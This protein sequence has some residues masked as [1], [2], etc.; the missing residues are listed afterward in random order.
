MTLIGLYSKKNDLN[1]RWNTCQYRSLA[2]SARTRDRGPGTIYLRD[3]G[4]DELYGFKWGNFWE[5]LY[6]LNGL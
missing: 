4:I 5:K 2:G 3:Y 6:F 1:F